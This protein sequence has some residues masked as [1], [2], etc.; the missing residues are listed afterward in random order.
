LS[1]ALAT[2]FKM[3]FDTLYMYDILLTSDC[4]GTQSE[5]AGKVEACAGCPNQT[6][7]ASSKP[8]GPD[9][10]NTCTCSL[11]FMFILWWQTGKLEYLV[12]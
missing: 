3:H 6:I 10:G 8:K 11:N 7:C 2:S 4:P 9:K 1:T 5:S 12:E